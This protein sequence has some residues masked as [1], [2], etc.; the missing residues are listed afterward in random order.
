MK[1]EYQSSSR[2]DFQS[3]DNNNHLRTQYLTN[4]QQA[5]SD[6]FKSSFH[7]TIGMEMRTTETIRTISS[8]RVKLLSFITIISHH[9]CYFFFFFL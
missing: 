8:V 1:F 5:V 6:E 4:N 3:V 2:K 7:S 9:N